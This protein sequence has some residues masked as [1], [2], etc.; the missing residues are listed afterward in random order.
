MTQGDMA[1]RDMAQ[2]DVGH[3]EMDYRDRARTK[4][5]NNLRLALAMFAV[6]LDAFE[7]RMSEEL[8]GT[9][10][11][12]SA[13]DTGAKLQKGSKLQKDMSSGGQ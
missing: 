12:A 6:Q 2:R 7:I 11:W 3:R 9:K 1:Q 8:L 5:L 10:T 4:E 13:R